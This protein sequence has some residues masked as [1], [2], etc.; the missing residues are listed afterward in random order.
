[1]TVKVTVALLSL[2]LCG[3]HAAQK[4]TKKNEVFVKERNDISRLYKFLPGVAAYQ[5]SRLVYLHD[6]TRQFTVHFKQP[7]VV[8]VATKPE[9]WGYFQ[10]PTI[11][12]RL[13]GS[14]AVKWNLNADAIEAYGNH[15]FGSAISTDG[16][17]SWQLAEVKESAGEV[18]LPNGDKIAVVTPKPIK[19]E[20]LQLPKPIGTG[21]DTYA[22][23]SSVFYKLDELPQ[24]RQGV[25]QKRLKK[26]SSE[27]QEEKATLYDPRAARYSFRGLVPVLFWGDMHIAGDQSLIAGIYPGFYI[28]DDGTVDPKSGAFFYRSTDNGHSWKIQGRVL[29]EPDTLLDSV[30]KKRMGFTEPA[31]E[32]MKDGSFI[33]INRTTDGLGIGPM[34]LS[35]STD[36]GKTWT[37]PQI[38]APSGVLPQLLRLDNGVTVLASGR[39]G[40]QLRFSTDESG[41]KWSDP[42]EMLPYKDQKDE[43]SCGYTGLMATG[44]NSFLIVYS[45]FKFE[46]EAKEIRKA[47]KVRE[48]VVT[49]Q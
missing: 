29:Y 21:M 20:E 44:P 49:P 4:A 39:P 48:V 25:F 5:D 6:D 34:Y 43:V 47:I 9:K 37:K 42:F 13:D 26:V 46:N 12:R 11:M 31:F 33:C 17:V 40:V 41:T 32:V 19:V 45:D 10:F 16:G 15:K 22:K 8:S 38:I 27:W 28:K 30:G 7:V 35:R 14:L 18:S 24:S 3:C 2:C 1:M 36:L 23:T